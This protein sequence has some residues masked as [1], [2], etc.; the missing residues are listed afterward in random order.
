MNTPINSIF[1]RYHLLHFEQLSLL[2]NILSF[3]CTS[4][5]SNSTIRCNN[6]MTW[7]VWGKRISLQSLPNSL[8]TTAPNTASQFAIRYSLPTR[9]IQQFQIN[10]SLK[11]CNVRCIHHHITNCIYFIHNIHPNLILYKAIHSTTSAA[12]MF[13]HNVHSPY[14]PTSNYTKNSAPVSAHS[15]LARG[16][17]MKK[18]GRRP[19]LPHCGAV[20][21]ARPGLTSLF[22]MGRGG[23]PG[24]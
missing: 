20:P 5:T 13:I 7:D 1:P 9:N 22:G 24:L 6:S 8:S 18:R 4:K 2:C 21:S 10:L 16:H 17:Y 19:T 14:P 23:T 3:S 12:S 15:A 11:L